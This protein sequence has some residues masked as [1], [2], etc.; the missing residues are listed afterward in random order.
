MQQ[1]FYWKHKDTDERRKQDCTNLVPADWD[2]M[3]IAALKTH[4]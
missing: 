4:Q 2:N 3:Q 1:F